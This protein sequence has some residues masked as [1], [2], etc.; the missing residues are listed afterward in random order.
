MERAWLDPRDHRGQSLSISS[1]HSPVLDGEVALGTSQW[2]CAAALEEALGQC[3]CQQDV[4]L[5]PA[6]TVMQLLHA[7]G[8]AVLEEVTGRADEA[9]NRGPSPSTAAWW[10]NKGRP[11]VPKTGGISFVSPH[12]F[13]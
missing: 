13:P 11:L 1:D 12:C 5:G 3:W 10:Q 6:V 8:S 9:G 2:L 7:R 4:T